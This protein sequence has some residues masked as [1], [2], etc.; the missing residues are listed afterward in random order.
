[1]AAGTDDIGPL[2][3]RIDTALRTRG[4]PERAEH[5]KGYLKSE[6]EHFGAGIQSARC[7]VAYINQVMQP[8]T[9]YTRVVME[10]GQVPYVIP[11]LVVRA[12]GPPAAPAAGRRGHDR[13]P[14][15]RGDLD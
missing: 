15:R 1:M 14:R 10:R 13:G 11:G 3:E 6:L 9:G 5:E 8:I 12:G 4:T 7:P 2:V